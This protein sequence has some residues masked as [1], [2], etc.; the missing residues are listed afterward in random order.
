LYFG[1]PKEYR[2][3]PGARFIYVSTDTSYKRARGIPVDSSND[4]RRIF[5][6]DQKSYTVFDNPYR[7]TS[8]AGVTN[9]EIAGVMMNYYRMYRRQGVEVRVETGGESL[10]RTNQQLIV[11]RARYGGQMEFGA[12]MAKITDSQA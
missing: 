3:S 8:A 1:I 9:A 10:A 11:V 6:M 4:A 5:G 2:N 12:A 7:I